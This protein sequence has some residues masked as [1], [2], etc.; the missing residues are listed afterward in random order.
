MLTKSR[1]FQ[2]RLI[3]LYDLLSTVDFFLDLD[4]LFFL[5]ALILLTNEFFTPSLFFL[6][7]DFFAGVFF[8]AV[9]FA[10]FTGVAFFLAAFFA[11][12][13]AVFFPFA[14]EFGLPLQIDKIY[15]NNVITITNHLII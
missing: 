7:L 13:F 3:L 6:L 4:A 9:F 10:L 15:A 5:R 2:L 14:I 8:L 11:T 12:F 1:Y